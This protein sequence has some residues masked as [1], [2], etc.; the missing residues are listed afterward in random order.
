MFLV[1]AGI[2][3]IWTKCSSAEWICNCTA[4]QETLLQSNQAL[5][6]NAGT[7]VTSSTRKNTGCKLSDEAKTR[8]QNMEL[9]RK[10]IC[11]LCKW[12]S[13]LFVFAA[14]VVVKVCY[15]CALTLHS[16]IAVG[17]FFEFQDQ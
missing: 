17:R 2:C 16:C 4:I 11:S 8:L 7:E 9:E 3:L 14:V 1:S 13:W 12:D 15:V 6:R 10:A 5:P